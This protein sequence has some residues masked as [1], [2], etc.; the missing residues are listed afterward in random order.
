MNDVGV[1]GADKFV[2]KIWQ[3]NII[4]AESVV[5]C[6]RVKVQLAGFQQVATGGLPLAYGL[7]SSAH[8]HRFR[9]GTLALAGRI[10]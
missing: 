6:F 5:T 9:V 3:Q 8:V 2:R 10:G 7:L 4:V 1:F